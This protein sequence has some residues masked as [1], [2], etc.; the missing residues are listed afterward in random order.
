MNA[1][2]RQSASEREKAK[3]LARKVEDLRT[4]VVDLKADK[5]RLETYLQSEDSGALYQDL[6]ACLQEYRALKS[7]YDETVN[8]VKLTLEKT[9]GETDFEILD[10]DTQ[11]LRVEI[12]RYLI[13]LKNT[14]NLIE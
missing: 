10:P 13:L 2:I 12:E 14:T 6:Q 11:Q 7:L 5:A 8:L 9:T 4:R 1:S 3:R